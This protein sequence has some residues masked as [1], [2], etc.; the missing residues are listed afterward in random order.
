MAKEA[1]RCVVDEQQR[2]GGKDVVS[3]VGRAFAAPCPVGA[4]AHLPFR[5][6]LDL[7][8]AVT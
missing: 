4:S 5:I 2:G 3:Q 6:F 8:R 7:S 1:A